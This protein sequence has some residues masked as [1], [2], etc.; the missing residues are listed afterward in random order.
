M[1]NVGSGWRDWAW[2]T[3][4]PPPEPPPLLRAVE[5]SGRRAP[6]WRNAAYPPPAAKATPRMPSKA[7]RSTRAPVRTSGVRRH[8]GGPGPRLD[9]ATRRRCGRGGRW[10]QARGLSSG[11]R[12]AGAAPFFAAP[13][14][15]ASPDCGTAPKA[16]GEAAGHAK[17]VYGHRTDKRQAL[18]M[19]VVPPSS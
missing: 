13:P 1:R 16:C 11:E 18:R 10:H 12:M 5:R 4:A 8:L 14:N 6:L 9:A 15:G 7:P 3:V 2:I 17:A 19:P